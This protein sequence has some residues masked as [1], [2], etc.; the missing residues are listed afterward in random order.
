MTHWKYL[1][2]IATIN[3]DLLKKKLL[4]SMHIVVLKVKIPWTLLF[5]LIF[6]VNIDEIVVI[7]WKLEEYWVRW[8][9][10]SVIKIF[11]GLKSA[12]SSTGFFHK[13][14]LVVAWRFR[15]QDLRIKKKSMKMQFQKN[16]TDSRK[17]IQCVCSSPIIKLSLDT[18]VGTLLHRKFSQ[19]FLL[20]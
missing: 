5:W 12:I 1:A 9:C 17:L 6:W 20:L 19:K 7:Y 3:K 15:I 18:K 14:S 13:I 10:V 11:F 16:I 4:L 8:L 2:T